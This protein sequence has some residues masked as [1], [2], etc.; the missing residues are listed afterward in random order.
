MLFKIVFFQLQ[1]TTFRKDHR[2]FMTSLENL[3]LTHAKAGKYDK[4]APILRGILKSKE[5]KLGPNHPST[6]ETMGILAFVLI[7]G[8]DLEEATVL[9]GKVSEWQKEYLEPSHPSVK[10]TNDAIHAVQSLMNGNSSL[11]I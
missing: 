6:I 4:S 8:I 11:W 1:S 2:F 7:K 3:A 9:L 5:S 10:M